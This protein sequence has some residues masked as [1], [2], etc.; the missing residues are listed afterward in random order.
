M[1]S[2]PSHDIARDTGIKRTDRPVGQYVDIIHVRLSG[3]QHAA[4]AFV[5]TP[6]SARRLSGVAFDNA[7][8]DPIAAKAASGVTL[9]SAAKPITSCQRRVRVAQPT[10]RTKTVCDHP[11]PEENL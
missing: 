3:L 10:L 6:E 2:D 7:P 11:D 8:R 5:V 9:E 1:L 4:T